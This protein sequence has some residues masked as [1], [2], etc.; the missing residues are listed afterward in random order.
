VSVDA[1]LVQREDNARGAVVPLRQHDADEWTRKIVRLKPENNV[2]RK[3]A[4]VVNN[5]TS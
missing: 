1:L 3:Q 5:K 2:D 4:G